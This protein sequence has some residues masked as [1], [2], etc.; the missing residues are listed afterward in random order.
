MTIGVTPSIRARSLLPAA[1]AACLP[2]ILPSAALACD[3]RDVAQGMATFN[4]CGTA[5]A[6]DSATDNGDIYACDA[7]DCGAQTVLR[8]T[9]AEMS[10]QDLGFGR[11]ALLADWRQ[12]IMPGELNGRRFEMLASI[13]T[14]TYGAQEGV[15]IPLRITGADGVVFHSLAFRV[16]LDGAYLVVNATGTIGAEKLNGFLRTAVENMTISREHRQ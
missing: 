6:W 3:T 14:E 16:P 5:W 11:E 8:V 1:F 9:R 12:R 2:F 4:S 10:E 13:S 7:A 15:L